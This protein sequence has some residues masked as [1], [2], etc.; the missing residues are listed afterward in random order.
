M[1]L[2]RWSYIGAGSILDVWIRPMQITTYQHRPAAGVSAC[3]KNTIIE[4]A[5]MIARHFDSSAMRSRSIAAGGDCAGIDD[6]A[7]IVG[8]VAAVDDDLAAVSICFI[9]D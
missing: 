5:H 3:V 1:D 8:I 2:S 9:G 6:R 4:C 7:R